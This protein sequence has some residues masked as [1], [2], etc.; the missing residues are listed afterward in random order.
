MKDAKRAGKGTVTNLMQ[1]NFNLLTDARSISYHYSSQKPR[2]RQQSRRTDEDSTSNEGEEAVE[3]D[4]KSQMLDRS[5]LAT[6]GQKHRNRSI[7]PDRIRKTF[8]KV[9][10]F[11]VSIRVLTEFN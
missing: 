9:P 5:L 11:R 1:N 8:L 4:A 7:T 3:E 10:E 6:D 2:E